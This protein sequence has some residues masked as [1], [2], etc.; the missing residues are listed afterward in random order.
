MYDDKIKIE[1]N[2]SQ[3]VLICSTIKAQIKEIEKTVKLF[4]SHKV[5]KISHETCDSIAKGFKQDQAEL[6]NILEQIYKGG[7]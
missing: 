2:P 5:N 7:I 6:E 3:R 4:E 1:L